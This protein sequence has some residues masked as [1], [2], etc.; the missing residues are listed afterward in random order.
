[1]AINDNHPGLLVAITL[2][3][4]TRN[5]HFSLSVAV[6][7]RTVAAALNKSKRLSG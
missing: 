6:G 5:R 7:W 2:P 4:T 3:R 1:V